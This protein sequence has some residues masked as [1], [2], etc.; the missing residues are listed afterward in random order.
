MS[1]SSVLRRG[2]ATTPLLATALGLGACSS[3]G[4]YSS[5]YHSDYVSPIAVSSAPRPTVPTASGG[6][7]GRRPLLPPVPEEQG[8]NGLPPVAM[9]TLLPPPVR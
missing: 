5:S 3:G 9:A 1:L 4:E 6:S 2:F 8:S 7:A